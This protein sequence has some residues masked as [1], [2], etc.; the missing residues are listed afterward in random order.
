MLLGVF[1]TLELVLAVYSN[2]A[3]AWVGAIFADL[4][5]LKPL[6]ISPSF[7]EF[8]R[9]YLYNINPVGCGAMAIASMV[10][11]MAFAGTF[12]PLVAAYSA[13]I[14]LSTAFV[15]GIL[16]GVITKGRYYIARHDTLLDDS[17]GSDRL[18]CVICNYDYESRDMALCP[19]YEG[20]VCSLCCSLEAHCHEICK[21]PPE[22]NILSDT[23]GSVAHFRRMIAPDLVRR[24]D[25]V[26]RRRCGPCSHHGGR[27]FADLSAD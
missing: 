7:I 11:I 9:A 3:I 25:E 17:D 15:V 13:G 14:S 16:L 1:E 10:S 8:K 22:T 24:V 12:G 4:V 2:V 5:V 18:R 23:P 20:A 6:G 27:L 19:F 26:L 21:S